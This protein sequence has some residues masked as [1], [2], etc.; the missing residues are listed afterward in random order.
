MTQN[1]EL[2]PATEKCPH[3]GGSGH[4]KEPSQWVYEGLRQHVEDCD[5]C[6]ISREDGLC[7][8][9]VSLKTPENSR[10]QYYCE[11]CRLTFRIH[12]NGTIS[13][14]WTIGTK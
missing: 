11:P 7:D 3:C 8:V 14:S 6:D 13:A 4:L 12:P 1:R 2:I 10:P 5:I 9:A